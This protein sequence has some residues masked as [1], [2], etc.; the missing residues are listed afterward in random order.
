M[1]WCVIL[2]YFEPFCFS[3]GKLSILDSKHEF[4]IEKL[5]MCSNVCNDLSNF[6]MIVI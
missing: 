2:R 6:K 1:F 3:I 5:S 4:A